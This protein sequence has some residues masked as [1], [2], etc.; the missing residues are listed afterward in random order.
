[1][2]WT[3]P[4]YSLLKQDDLDDCGRRDTDHIEKLKM[5]LYRAALEL[6]AACTK[7]GITDF[8]LKSL[9][10]D[11]PVKG[12]DTVLASEEVDVI[13]NIIGEEYGVKFIVYDSINSVPTLYGKAS[14]V[15]NKI[16]SFG[17]NTKSKELF[18]TKS[19]NEKLESIGE[20]E[21]K[22]EL[23]SVRY[24][25]T[26]HIKNG[27]HKDCLQLLRFLS[28]HVDRRKN[29]FTFTKCQFHCDEICEYCQLN[30]PIVKRS[31][32]FVRGSSICMLEPTLSP[33]HENH[34]MTFLEMAE[35]TENGDTKHFAEPGEGCSLDKEFG[36]SLECKHWIF[37]SKA[38][39][40]RH[41]SLLHPK[42][43][44]KNVETRKDLL[45]HR[46]TF[47]G[48]GLV[49]KSYHTLR[50]HKKEITP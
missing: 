40:K 49:F 15:A 14:S 25:S 27:H 37:S 34:Y 47:K 33:T 32:E 22:V 43:G 7:E 6:D 36:K 29:E 2:C 12:N 4:L 11:Q 42:Y 50:N 17:Y 46:C 10:T 44:S 1:M 45:Q 21:A 31:L 28:E 16:I 8:V 5:H 39:K 3:A 24:Q 20:Y 19:L 23:A 30:P 35:A 13:L 26:K 41:I 38:E 9:S 48:C 18:R